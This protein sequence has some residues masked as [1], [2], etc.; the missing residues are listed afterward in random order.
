[1]NAKKK[2]KR[3]NEQTSARYVQ[4]VWFGH[5]HTTACVA[6]GKPESNEKKKFT[7]ETAVKWMNLMN[8]YAMCGVRCAVNKSFNL[9]L[10]LIDTL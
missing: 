8:I 5:V 7:K 9:K 2:P 1:M 6:T 3:G 10:A 4:F